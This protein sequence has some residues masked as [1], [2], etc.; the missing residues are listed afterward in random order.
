MSEKELE[1]MDTYHTY[2]VP[3]PFFFLHSEMLDYSYSSPE[4]SPNTTQSNV[5]IH[6]TARAKTQTKINRRAQIK[7]THPVLFSCFASCLV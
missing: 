3:L 4:L 1:E 7:I 5:N 6:N 2:Q